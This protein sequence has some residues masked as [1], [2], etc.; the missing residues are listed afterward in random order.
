[1]RFLKKSMYCSRASGVV[2]QTA[3]SAARRSRA[4]RACGS[5]TG[6]PRRGTA[7]RARRR[8][9][10]TRGSRTAWRSRPGRRGTA[11]RR[12][13]RACAPSAR[14]ARARTGSA[15]RSRRSSAS[16]PVRLRQSLARVGDVAHVVAQD[17][18]RH[19]AQVAAGVGVVADEGDARRR[20]T[21]A[22][23]SR[24]ARR[25]RLGAVSTSR[26][27]GRRCSRSRPSS[28]VQLAGHA[29]LANPQLLD[30]APAPRSQ[31]AAAPAARPARSPPARRRRRRTLAS[32]R[33]CAIESAL[34]PSP[35][36]SSSTRHA[37]AGAGSS[38]NSLPTA[39]SAP[40]AS[41][42]R[43]SPGR[44]G[45]R[46]PRRRSE[47]QVCRDV[48]RHRRHHLVVGRRTTLAF[49][50]L[51]VTCSGG[52]SA[53]AVLDGG[54]Q[55]VGELELQVVLPGRPPCARRTPRTSGAAPRSPRTAPARTCR[56][57]S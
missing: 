16:A 26:R 42:G 43:R 54:D 18:A 7:S 1:M 24:A 8:A 17:V 56:A 4:R 10:R 45:A 29:G 52:A 11:A 55:H 13:S 3:S 35:Q 40:D 36:P 12:G 25:A 20:Q 31:P 47:L 5:R 57:S 2:G 46:R 38:P 39:S 49:W 28:S 33:V 48:D 9:R 27:R 37:R 22:R 15:R 44:R 30:V 50:K 6:R 21:V 23:S 14:A 34:P 51:N 19:V 32:G 53:A 41:P